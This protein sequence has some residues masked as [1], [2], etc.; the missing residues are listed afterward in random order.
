[1]NSSLPAEILRLIDRALTAVQT[2]PKHMLLPF[3]RR[4]IYRSI[5]KAA[6]PKAHKIKAALSILAAEHVV[7]YWNI[8]LF[9]VE[10][11]KKIV[12][13]GFISPVI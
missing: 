7:P 6:G 5:D 1:M 11:M 13:I 4:A 3:Y 12:I 8:P 2:H 10:K 9:M